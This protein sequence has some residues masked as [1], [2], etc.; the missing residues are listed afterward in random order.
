M[1]PVPFRQSVCNEIF[2]QT[3]F[4]E[5]CREIRAAGYAGVEIAP[6]TLA[7]DATALAQG[8]RDELRRHMQDQDLC[9]TGFVWGLSAPD[10]LQL[11]ARDERIRTRSWEYLYR[12]IDLCGDLSVCQDEFNANMVL[13]SPRQRAAV[14]GMTKREATDL[15]THGLAYAAPLAESRG[16]RLIIDALSP[17]QTDVV[18]SLEEAVAIV[19]Q[20]GSPALQAMFDTRSASAEEQTHAELI[21]RYAPYIHHVYVSE[22]DGRQPGKGDYD[23]AALF[24]ALS[25]AK[26][27]G[28][29]SL[30]FSS[31]MSKDLEQAGSPR[32]MIEQSL[33]TLQHRMP[34]L[35]FTQTV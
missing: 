26:Y 25:A 4:A 3:A 6:T 33:Q 12:T 18:T 20:V 13:A 5:V 9:F 28:W 15:F 27:G 11:T 7:D 1:A 24:R 32:Q 22:A 30:P 35:A 8:E 16:V 17:E 10:W 21:R 34:E 23:F 29:I 19:R 31:S 2:G 14:E